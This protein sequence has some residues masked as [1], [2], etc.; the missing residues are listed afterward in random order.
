[1]SWLLWIMD[2]A[3]NNRYTPYNEL[4]GLPGTVSNMK[5]E[6]FKMCMIEA[7]VWRGGSLSNQKP[8]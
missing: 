2:I 3:V 6:D 5:F 8:F 1:M 4:K 7:F